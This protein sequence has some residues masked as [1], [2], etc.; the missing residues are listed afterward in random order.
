M[1]KSRTPP[2]LAIA[3]V[4]SPAAA[5][6]TAVDRLIERQRAELRAA[7]QPECEPGDDPEEIVVCA[8]RVD[9]RRYRLPIPDRPAAQAD[10][11][12]GGEQR[13]ALAIDASP[14]TAV[15]RDQRCN[16][17]LDVIG[18]AF[19]VARAIVQKLAERD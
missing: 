1:A 4:S 5:D 15:G 18:I 2:W 19:T 16:A 12:A 9:D 13:A 8:A 7:L 3:L 10:R 17:G 11:Q 14:C 6:P